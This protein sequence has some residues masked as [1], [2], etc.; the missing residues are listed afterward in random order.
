MKISINCGGILCR[1][2]AT[3]D[4]E[5]PGWAARLDGI[6]VEESTYIHCPDCAGESEWMDAVCCGCAGGLPECGLGRATLY[7]EYSPGLTQEQADT[8]AAGRC[9][10]R[11]NGT[12]SA[13]LGGDPSFRP[14]DIS[15]K[16]TTE[17]GLAMLRGFRRY[18]DEYGPPP[19]WAMPG[20]EG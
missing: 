5:M 15:E 17:S 7:G 20:T 14:V 13:G 10:F 9:P 16:A 8:I 12:F 18:A 4:V 3:F 6:Y 1:N 19:E 2:N 11:A